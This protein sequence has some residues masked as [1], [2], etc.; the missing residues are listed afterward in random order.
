MINKAIIIGCPGSGKTTFAEKLQK[1]TGLPLYYLDTIWHKPD[2]THIPR[3]EFDARIKEVFSTP[4]WIIDGNYSRTIEMRMAECDTVFLFDLPTDICIQGVNERLG[5]GRYDLPWIETELDSEF[6]A[7]IREFPKITLPKIYGL[8]EKYSS[9]K[10]VVIFKSREEADEYLHSLQ[11]EYFEYMVKSDFP[12]VAPVIFAILADNMEKIAPTGNTR[13]EDFDC[14]Y[15]CVKDGLEKE[16]RQ[17]VLIKNADGNIIGY[18]QYFTNSNT[19]RME[20]IQLKPEYHGKGIFRKLYGYVLKNIRTDIEFVDA[21]A[22]INNEKSIG[23]LTRFGLENVGLNKNGRSYY[24]N[25]KFSKLI[26]WYE[27]EDIQKT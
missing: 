12:S 16:E 13:E 3:E 1:C 18:F 5:K 14:W 27:N 8:I 17:I 11:E 2:K 4:E 26:E 10:Q 7:F 15:G 24:F 19:F 9:E 22:S 21:F 23:I 6:E 25:G 20:E